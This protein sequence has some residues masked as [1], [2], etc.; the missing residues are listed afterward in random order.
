[1]ALA[2]WHQGFANQLRPYVGVRQREGEVSK[3]K[4]TPFKI[5]GC[6]E[7]FSEFETKLHGAED[8]V[9]PPEDNMD[10]SKKTFLHDGFSV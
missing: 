6:V 3:K 7:G 10:S 5:T 4:R 8:T 2:V 1:M 9:H